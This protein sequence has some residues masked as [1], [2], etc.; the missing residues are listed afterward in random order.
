MRTSQLQAQQMLDVVLA[1]KCRLQR[2][3]FSLDLGFWLL[4]NKIG[5]DCRGKI[6]TPG[7]SPYTGGSE[8][9][10]PGFGF[11][12]L[13][14]LLSQPVPSISSKHLYTNPEIQASIDTA[15]RSF[16]LR[17]PRLLSARSHTPCATAQAR[18]RCCRLL[19]VQGLAGR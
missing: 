19:Q 6:K 18:R 11:G 10:W 5:W 17:P 16:S 8:L 9:G 1:Q 4:R 15:S 14:E 12:P 2:R 7:P 13:F 3:V